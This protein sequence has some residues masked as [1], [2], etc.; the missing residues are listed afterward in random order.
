MQEM[1]TKQTIRW[2]G[3][4]RNKSGKAKRVLNSDFDEEKDLPSI[5]ER[6][7][8]TME[9]KQEMNFIDKDE[10]EASPASENYASSSSTST[11]E[12]KQDKEVKMKYKYLHQL[13]LMLLISLHLH[14]LHQPM[15][16]I[17][18]K[19]LEQKMNQDHLHHLLLMLVKFFTC[20]IYIKQW[21]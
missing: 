19:I 20:I 10:L 12:K 14:H 6:S 9:N 7:K 8:S 17:L 3:R 21:K 15:N 18:R 11:N 13:M 16:M 4:K 1:K 5:T 2:G